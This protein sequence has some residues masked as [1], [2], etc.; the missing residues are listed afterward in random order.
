MGCLDDQV[1][2]DCKELIVTVQ[3]MFNSIQRLIS[4]PPLHILWSTKEWKFLKQIV[5]QLDDIA[6][7]HVREKLEKIRKENQN[8][9][10]EES[11]IPDKVDFLTYIM[12]SDKQSL[13]EA[14]ANA[15][16]LMIGG[17]DNVRCYN[18]VASQ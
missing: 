7:N 18:C 9:S 12:H 1:P 13:K 14:A 11:E 16:D 15:A 2:Q 17:V 8:G 6:L 10:L 5:K 4:G 3:E